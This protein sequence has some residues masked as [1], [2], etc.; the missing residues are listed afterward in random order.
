V[1]FPSAWDLLTAFVVTVV[2]ALAAGLFVP[3]KKKLNL[4]IW[5]VLMLVAC[6]AGLAGALKVLLGASGAPLVFFW[7]SWSLGWVGVDALGAFFLVP[8][9]VVGGLGALYSIGYQHPPTA[10]DGSRQ[11]SFFWGTALVGMVLLIVARNGLVFLLGWE[12]MALS[13]Y[14]LIVSPDTNPESRK[15]AW[16]YFIA[17]HLST[18]LLF[19][20]F[21]LWKHV[22]GSFFLGTLS[23]ALVE[24]AGPGLLY[25]IFFLAVAGFGLKAGIMPL[26]FWLPGAHAAAPSPVSGLLSGVFLKMGIFGLVRILS[27]IPHPPAF[28][29]ETLLALGAISGVLGVV[30]ALAQHDLKRLLAYHSVENIGIIV[31]GLGLALLG[32]TYHQPLW[33]VLGMA[34]ALLHVWNHAFFKAL[35]FF[36]AGSVVRQTGTRKMDDLGGLGRWMPWTSVL[37][38]GGAAAISGLPP[39]NGFISE[40]FLYLGGLRSLSDGVAGSLLSLAVLPVLAAIGALALA[41]F[42]KVSGTVFLGSPRRELSPTPHESPVTMLGPMLVLLALCLF[43]G[44]F[45]VALAPILDSVVPLVAGTGFPLPLPSLAT[46]APLQALSWAVLVLLGLMIVVGV[47]ILWAKKARPGPTWDCG[48][49]RP[50][51]RMQY[52]SSSFSRPIR[53]LFSWVVRETPRSSPGLVGRWWKILS[54]R[55]PQKIKSFQQGMTQQYVLYVLI[56]A[57]LV[58]ATQIPFDAILKAVFG[59]GF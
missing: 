6:G 56:A 45:P 39:F 9:F 34:G 18:L 14:F 11:L 5:A 15:A 22:S 49:A 23:S 40:F 20:L 10:W 12:I 2:A 17:T 35:L 41:C 55:V 8:V 29:G 52:T 31:M 19:L 32:R 24:K 3:N 13:A 57:L 4:K 36:G 33:V 30:M 42:V 37:F 51:P 28:W 16:V 1:V 44:V 38:L 50:T 7:P 46:V 26:H 59:G 25:L 58:L 43:I 47:I 53:Q 27:L 48:Y 54:R 21:L